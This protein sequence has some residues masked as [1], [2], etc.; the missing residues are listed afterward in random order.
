MSETK[1]RKPWS[2]RKIMLVRSALVFA[3]A[4]IFGGWIWISAAKLQFGNEEFSAEEMQRNTRKV[5]VEAVRGN[6]YAN[7]G[8][9]L[10]TSVPRYELV[11]DAKVQGCPSDTFAKYIDSFC[12]LLAQLQDRPYWKL[13]DSERKSQQQWKEYLYNLRNRG[14]HYR[15]LLKNLGFDQ[16]KEIREWPLV[17]LGK[18]KGGIWFIEDSQ[19]M[20]FLG[21]LAKRAIGYSRNGVYV[22]LEGAFDS[23]LSGVNGER[24]EQRMPGRIW[25]PIKLDNLQEPMNGHDIVTTL[26]VGIQDIAQFALSKALT[27]SQA[28]YGCAV[29][30][31]V[32]TGEI[33]AMANLKRGSDGQ[34][35]E[36]QNYAIDQYSEPGSTFK[37]YS[38]LN[39]LEDGYAKAQDSVRVGN[40]VKHFYDRDMFDDHTPKSPFMTLKEAYIQSSNVGISTFV[41]NAYNSNRAKFI[42][43]ALEM[44]FNKPLDFDIPGRNAP[45]IHNPANKK[46]WSGT[47]LPWMSIGYECNISPLQ[48]L[49]LYN[50]I[51]N[52]GILMKPFLV[53]EIR[54]DGRIIRQQEPT[55]L[56]NHLCSQNTVDVITSMMI[57]VVQ[58]GTAQ[59]IKDA[60]YLI[61]G[62]TGT[63]KVS[64]GKNGYKTGAYNSS[65]CG[66]FPADNPQYSIVV[67][68]SEP[69]GRNLYGGQVAAPVFK[70]IADRIYASH[71]ANQPALQ[72]ISLPS[73]PQILSGRLEP[74]KLLLNELGISSSLIGTINGGW[75]SATDLE[76]SVSLKSLTPV[77]PGTMPELRGMGLRDALEILNSLGARVD[78][79]GYGRISAQSLPAGSRI[80]KGQS[81][82]LVLKPF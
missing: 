41:Y 60:E 63:A 37:L 80:S 42:Q 40:G 82:T 35:Y 29:V 57:G 76:H 32:K 73:V 15:V 6:I 2:V 1:T 20:Y 70:D 67:W 75:I 45:L 36:S 33:K 21:D 4:V 46:S 77:Q 30:M 26:D 69:K 66:F 31:N 34:Y 25:R 12:L 51:A 65:F 78:F 72:N 71:I 13:R 5:V 74:T 47:T 56:N 49:M 17:R 55:V 8:S 61:A 64:N 16:V 48:T 58:N 9:L 3:I 7:D 24:M 68:I 27:T 39:L 11:M 50:A 14:I 10:A 22:G 53:K 44:G 23:L 54:Q 18:Y 59:T 79:E 19:R 62:K 43:R 38:V 52:N 81:V 28:A